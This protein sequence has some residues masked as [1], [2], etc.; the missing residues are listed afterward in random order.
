[1]FTKNKL[2][3]KERERSE[4]HNWYAWTQGDVTVEIHFEN[5]SYNSI[6]LET[7]TFDDYFDIEELEDIHNC[8][9][10]ALGWLKKYTDK[11]RKSN[12]R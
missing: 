8:T 7:S 3:F 11:L 6:H 9:G 1:M 12:V 5:G 10:K 2:G 4:Q